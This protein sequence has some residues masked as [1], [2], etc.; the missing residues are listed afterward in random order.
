MEVN[1]ASLVV[2]VFL[3]FPVTSVPSKCF[4]SLSTFPLRFQRSENK[5]L[6]RFY[7]TDYDNFVGLLGKRHAASTLIRKA[8]SLCV[9]LGRRMQELAKCTCVCV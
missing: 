3:I 1:L 5:L 9:S 4:T 2:L 6:K 7:P 8:H